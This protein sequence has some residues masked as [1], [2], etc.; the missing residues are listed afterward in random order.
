MIYKLNS[1]SAVIQNTITYK[2]IYIRKKKNKPLDSKLLCNSTISV[3]RV[4][5]SKL[6]LFF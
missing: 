3:I 6:N 1:R 5:N 4:D 2:C